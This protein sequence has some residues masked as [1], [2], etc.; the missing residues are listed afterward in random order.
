MA[1]FDEFPLGFD[2]THEEVQAG[3]LGEM[4]LAELPCSAPSD[5]PKDMPVDWFTQ[6]SQGSWPFCHS[7]MRTACAEFLYWLATKGKVVQY[8]RAFG[9]ITNLRMDGNDSRPAGASISGS[10]RAANKYGEALEDL[11]PYFK[12]GIY[13][14]QIPA[15]VSDNASKHRIEKVVPSCRSYDQ[16][17]AALTTGLFALA[18]GFTWTTGWDAVRGQQFLDGIPGGRVRGGHALAGFG[19][20]TRAGERWY[21]LH[22]SHD[23]WG[24]NM[25]C[26]LSPKTWDNLLRNSPYGANLVSDIKITDETVSRDWEWLAGMNFD[27]GGVQI[28]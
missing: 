1:E 24:T 4:L 16:M 10:M 3:Q 22:N 11:F 21:C 23:G 19:W 13:T 26:Y 9:A 18:L 7:H 28:A 2:E 20:L 27:A 8:S 14:N 15:S 25:R 12:N 17:D 5:I 6:Q